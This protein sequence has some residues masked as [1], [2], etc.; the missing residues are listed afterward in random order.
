MHIDVEISRAV[1]VTA[2][3]IKALFWGQ[4]GAQGFG[5]RFCHL[6]SYR[7]QLAAT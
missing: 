2:T 4:Y 1:I 3:Q 6:G 7:A 5:K